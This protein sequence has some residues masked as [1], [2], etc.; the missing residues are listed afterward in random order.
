MS[1]ARADRNLLF[2]ILALQMDFVTREQLVAGMNSWVLDKGKPLGAILLGQGALRDDTH[3]LLEAL[4]RKHLEMHGNDPGQSLAALGSADSARERLR[5]VA[6]ADVQASLARVPQGRR[7]EDDL[8]ATRAPSVGTPTSAG[9]RFRILRPHARGGLGEVFV[10]RDEELHREV[11]LKE[12]QGRSADDPESRARFLLE[13]EITG[14]LEHPGIVPVYG[15]GSYADGRPF[16]AMRFIKG[17]SLKEAA[18]RFH[19]DEA[20]RRDPGKR[21]L[22]L[23]GLLGRFI[24]VCDAIAYAHSRGV[25][26]R[27]LKPGNI[28]LGKYGET[29]V[30]DWGLAKPLEKVE[31]AGESPEEPL[32]PASLSGTAPTLAGPAVGT[33]QY[34]SPEQAAGRLDRLGP[35]SDVYSLGATLYNL[36]TGRPPFTDAD[37]GAVLRRV[38]GGDF[39]RPRQVS[40]DLPPPLEAICLKAMA[41]RP[42]DRYASPRALAADVERW[43]ADEPVGAWPEPWSVKARRWVGRHRPLVAAAAAAVLVA[44]V[45]LA[46]GAALLARANEELRAANERERQARELAQQ[47]HERAEHNYQLARKAVDRYHTEVS[48]DVL[49]HEPGMEPLRKKLLEAAR[50]FY[51]QFVQ[52]RRGDEAAEADLGKSLYRLAQITG[53]I[54]SEVRAIDLHEQA[55][56]IFARRAESQADLAASYHQLGRL[57]RLTDRPGRAEECYAKALALWEELA[58]RQPGEDG[59]Q[60]ELARSRLG[61]GNVFLKAHRLDRARELYEQALAARRELHGRHPDVVEHQRDLAVTLNNLGMAHAGLG[62]RDRAEECYQEAL[63]LQ[64]DLVAAHANVGQYQNDLARS[65]YNLGDWYAQSS[66]PGRA[67]ESYR[68]AA[69][70]WERLTKEHPAVATYQT[71]L[72]DAY[73]ALAD[74]YRATRQV[75]RAEEACE[76]ALAIKQKLADEHPKVPDY[77]GGLALGYYHLGNAYRAGNHADKAEQA[78][79]SALGIQGRLTDD[80]P[81]SPQFRADLARTWDRLGLLRSDV[82]QRDGAAAAYRTAIAAWEGLVG[83]RPG[84]P[85]FVLGLAVSRQNLGNLDRENGDLPGALEAY[86]GALRTLEGLAPQEQRPALV[87][88]ALCNALWRRAETLTQMRRHAEA[89]PDWGRALGFAAEANRGWF[90][91]QHTLALAR[92]GEHV[93]AAAAAAEFAKQEGLPG[94]ALYGLACVEALALTAAAG[95][96]KLAPDERQRLAEAYAARGLALVEKARAAGY[97]QAPANRERLKTDPDLASLRS[98]PEFEQ[99]LRPPPE[100][101]KPPR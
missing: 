62:R 5:Q 99:L 60:A 54:D 76:R 81:A 10:A 61:L 72:A 15:L 85:E 70:L 31:G 13:A 73:T 95:D 43:L 96:A 83:E 12:I 101:T 22:E 37:V 58:R 64:K 4:V 11:A 75:A 88:Q 1:P 16:Y 6:D 24:D 42:E 45:G 71:T 77:Q 91:L 80:L 34:M 44:L 56:Q 65:H 78:Y 26:H 53:D 20:L 8:Y 35:A 51:D 28:M 89:V 63:R 69:G 84:E 29:L 9:A 21:A 39:P 30:V 50:E 82:K 90:R 47:Q 68:A 18:E 92:A 59:Y 66:Q 38:Q 19:K 52:E 23:R 33:P 40:R 86:T 100:A 55:L 98:R 49:L 3:A 14:G 57:Y 79:Q 87:R 2:G 94:D 74:V 93:A 48:Q 7:G 32:R 17:D 25:L 97:F 27:D 46:L 67:E 41:L 36:L